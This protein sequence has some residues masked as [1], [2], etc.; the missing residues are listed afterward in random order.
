MALLGYPKS[1]VKGESVVS[2]GAIMG[3]DFISGG[4]R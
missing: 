1:L 3:A 4:A 2:S